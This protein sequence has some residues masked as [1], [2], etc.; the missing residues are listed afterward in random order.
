MSNNPDKAPPSLSECK[1]YEDWK[2]VVNIWGKFTKME[3]KKQGMAVLLSLKGAAQ[4]A[5]LELEEDKIDCN[6][7][8]K[9]VLARLDKLYLK[10]ETLTKYQALED[11]E[12]YKRPQ[13]L[14]I[15]DYIIQFD[16]R[17]HKIKSYGTTISEDLLAFRLLKSAKLSPADEKLAKG[18]ATALKYDAMKTQL[19]KLFSENTSFNNEPAA[20][21]IEDINQ[22]SL[23]NDDDDE[24]Q[25]LYAAQRRFYR[26]S[27]QSNLTRNQTT[28]R[29]LD[30]T[31]QRPTASSN[32]TSQ[33]PSSSKQ[34]RNPLNNYGHITRCA[35]CDSINHWAAK[36]PDK[37]SLPQSSSI[38]PT[39]F[40]AMTTDNVSD[41]HLQSNNDLVSNDYEIVMY[42][43]DYDHPSQMKGLLA[44]SLNTAVLDSGASK[45][46][47]GQNWFNIF[48]GSLTP[49]E[50]SKITISPSSNIYK[51][52]DGKKSKVFK[53]SHYSSNN[54]QQ[55][56]QNCNR[57][58]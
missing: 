15:V 11:F 26:S 14:P 1:T 2:K 46:V 31:C 35:V 3:V 49:T 48:A 27:N 8:L 42:Q 23:Y 6:D 40:H 57:Y 18:T 32:K 22:L 30:Q 9:N 33:R 43:S 16:K 58:S 54:W 4:E 25:I 20:S 52:G 47:C 12:S 17:Y 36:C 41:Q 7:G 53:T 34:G 45:T 39:Y 19:K 24:E 10:D 44:E 56:G 21:N 5:V 37:N 50:R 29:T 38:Q 55:D 51:F 13:N 28:W